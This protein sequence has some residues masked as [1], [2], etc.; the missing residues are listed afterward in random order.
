MINELQAA[1][2]PWYAKHGRHLP[3]RRKVT[4]YGVWVSEIM[5]QQTRVEA[6]REKYRSFMR[7]F[8]N[9]RTLAAATI[10]DVLAAWSGLGY[11]RRARMLHETAR[12]IVSLHRGRFPRDFDVVLRLPGIGRYTAGAIMSIA[13]DKP[14]PIVDANVERVFARLY[15]IDEPGKQ[16]VWNFAADWVAY[17]AENGLSPGR[18]NQALM[19]LG[20]MV[21]TPANPRCDEC[22]VNELCNARQ[23]NDV[24]HYPAKPPQKLKRDMRYFVLR[25]EDAKGRVLM[26]QR[27]QDDNSSLL[28][29][30]LWEL[31]H[32]E[33]P[34]DAP[35]PQLEASEW[36]AAGEAIEVSHSIM[37]YRVTLHVQ[38]AKGRAEGHWFTME[39]AENAAISSA[40]RKTLFAGFRG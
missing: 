1:L 14:Y 33:W 27:P 8:P 6:V 13:F 25:L 7:R 11:Y 34:P 23:H 32:A 35:P 40:T 21:C 37:D 24:A 5:L 4:P 16:G 9:L 29:A 19:D 17:A 15:R 20:A 10:D 38:P 2:E 12:K 3:W 30:G 18:V 39:E 28:P 36:Q 26:R 31:P 22:P